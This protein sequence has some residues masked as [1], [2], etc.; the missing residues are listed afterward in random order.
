MATNEDTA[1]TSAVNVD[2]I[3]NSPKEGYDKKCIFC[4]IVNKEMSTELLHSVGN[5]V[6]IN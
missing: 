4:K 2:K 6:H 5:T 3:G 1:D